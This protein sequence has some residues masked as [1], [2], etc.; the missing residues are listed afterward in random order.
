MVA[1]KPGKEDSKSVILLLNRDMFKHAKVI[2]IDNGPAFRSDHLKRWADERNIELRFTAPY[3]PE[4]NGLAERAIRDVKQF[5]ALYPGF[6]GGWKCALEAA[7]NHHNH[8]HTAGLGCTPYF[9]YHGKL[10]WLPA[11]HLLGIA[12]LLVVQE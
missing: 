7:V 2:V 8:S 12:N 4:A 6:P 5:I 9:A 3:H 1:Y 10:E 11:D